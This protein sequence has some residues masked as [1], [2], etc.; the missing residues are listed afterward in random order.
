MTIS[1]TMVAVLLFVAGMCGAIAQTITGYTRTG[2]IG[3]IA[4]G[5]IGALLGTWLARALRLPEV[6]EIQIGPEVFP[7]VWSVA[8]AA[9]F[10]ALLGL[11]TRYRGRTYA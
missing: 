4:L 1:L 8:G 9:L 10:V 2:C 5:F 11:L 3:S 7:V 6:L